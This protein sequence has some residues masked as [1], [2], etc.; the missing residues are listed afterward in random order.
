MNTKIKIV[1]T[2]SVEK[3]K[4]IIKKSE[5][6]EGVISVKIDGSG[7]LS[8]VISEWSSDY[9]VMVSIMNIIEEEGFDSEPLFDGGDEMVE[10]VNTFE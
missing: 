1:G 4:Y 6:I 2:L 8:Y 9:D 10:S 7:I 3:S 5:Q